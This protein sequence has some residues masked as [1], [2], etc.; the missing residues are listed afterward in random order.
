MLQPLVMGRALRLRPAVILVAVA[1]A[2]LLAGIAGAVVAV[3]AIAVAYR[4][5]AALRRPDPG[6]PG[7]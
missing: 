3:P 4:F 1:V 7:A 6:N 2:G 5:A